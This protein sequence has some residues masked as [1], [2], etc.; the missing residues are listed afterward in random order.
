MHLST[1]KTGGA[2][3]RG[4]ASVGRRLGKWLAGGLA[5][6]L[7]GTAMVASGTGIIP[8]SAMEG[9][10]L[11]LV[12]SVDGEHAK[13]DLRPGDS[14]VYRVEFR[15]N[16][17]DADAPVLVRDAL[18][19][20]FA[21]W[22]ISNLTAVVGGSV[23]NVTLDLPGITSGDSPM[24]PA[25]GTIGSSEAERTITVG[26]AQPVQA[27][28]GN[29]SGLGMSTR[30]SGVLEYT[31]T[32]PGGLSPDDPI[33]R[34]DLVNTA[35]FTAKS[36]A[37]DLSTSDTAI[38]SVDNPIAVDVEP[39]KTWTPAAQNY[40]PGAASNMVIGARQ[41]SNVDASRLILQDPV[42]AQN[43]QTSL[44]ADNPFNYVD[45]AGFNAPAD[46]TGN[47]PTGADSVDVEV[48]R[49]NGTTWNWE[50]WNA[51]IPGSQ[52]G[53]IRT[54]YTGT[55]PPNATVSQGFAV[56]QRAT[57]RASGD[58]VSAGY[59]TLNRVRATVEVPGQDSVSKNAE[60]PFEVARERIGVVAQK[61]F[62][63]LPDGTPTTNLTEVTAGET[64]GVVLRAG[65]L[66]VPQST[67]LDRLIIAEPGDPAAPNNKF[68]DDDLVFGGFTSIS[69]P[70]GATGATVTWAHDGGPTGPVSF[71]SGTVPAPPAGEDV[72]GFT[73]E[74]TGAIAPNS[75]A[76]I[77]YELDSNASDAFVGPGE[78]KGPFLNIVDVTGERAGLDPVTESAE[79]SVSY[80]APKIE[81]TI[82]KRVGP[83]TVMPGQ[84]VIVQLDT[85]S[86]A[87]GGRTKPTKIE[88]TDEYTGAGTFWDAFDAKQI[89]PPISRPVNNGVPAT[90]T[91]EYLP[92][93]STVWQSLSVNPDENTPITVPNDA[94]GLR[95]A[96]ENTTEGLSKV[97]YVKPNI[98]FEARATLR[99]SGEPTGG[100]FTD[101]EM[102]RNTATVETEGWLDARKVEGDDADTADVGIRGTEGGTGPVPGEGPWAAKAWA[103]DVLTSQSGASS[104]TT[105]SWAVTEPGFETV[106]LQDPAS[107]T[108][109]AAKGEGTVF[110]AFNLTSI[111]PI[112]LSG[113]AGSGTVD[114]QLRWDLVTDVQLFNGTTGAWESVTPVPGGSW[115][116][117]GGFK[118]YTLTAAQQQSTVGVRLV[119][120]ENGPARQAAADAG[121]LTAPAVGSGVAA[122]AD[123]RQFRLDWQLRERAR[124]ADGSL[125]W[126]T[127]S[128]GFNCSGASLGCIDNV[129]GVTAV[130]G[131]TSQ[132]YT[133]SD[134][135]QLL[136][137]KANVA[138]TKDVRPLP[139]ADPAPAETVLVAPNEGEIAQADYPRARYTLT[140]TNSSQMP[141][142]AGGNPT[143]RGAMKLGKIR[144]TDT[145]TDAGL[146]PGFD[147]ATSPFTDRDFATEVNS[148]EG[149][150][151]D[152][153]TLT[154]VSFGT[155]PAYIDTAESTVELW[156]FGAP[157]GTPNQ[158][159]LAQ[160]QA[161]DPA[162]TA[163][164]QYAVG[165]AVTYSGTDPAQN[166][167]R[168]VVG[169]ALVAHLD[170][171]LRSH[172]RL[173]PTAPVTGGAAP[174]TV[175]VPNQAI[176]R[177]W[178][179]VVNPSDQPTDDDG[180]LVKL[181]EAQVRVSLEKSVSVSHG[182]TS[183]K[184]VYETDPQ[185]PISV[186]L[187]ARSSDAFGNST[188]PLNDLSISDRTDDFWDR[189]EFVSFG[190]PTHPSNADTAAFRVY[191]G[192]DWV[193]YDDFVAGGGDLA[194]IRGAGVVFTRSDGG[195]F[196]QGATSWN[197]S[198]GTA[199]LP[200]TVKLRADAVVD[201]SGDE[202]P[203][204]AA[205][206]ANNEQYG[207]AS[208]G[209]DDR[210]TFSPGV[211]QLR[212][213]KRA[214]N[215]TSTHQVEPLISLPW[216][217]QFTNTG[218]S[219]LP[220]TT[221]TDALP[222]TLSWDGEDPV[223]TSSVATSEL[224]AN[225]PDLFV[226]SSELV[227]DWSGSAPRMQPG[228]TV[229]IDLGLIMQPMTAGSRAT[230]EVVVRTGVPLAVCEQ[231]TD[232]GQDP[233]AWDPATPDE[234][235]NTNFVQPRV[236]TVIGARKTVSGEPGD[237]LG[238]NL[239]NGAL[240]VRNGEECKPG[241]FL[242]IG[243]DY[244]RNPCASYT[245]VG[246]TD[247]WKLENI[248][249][250]TQPFSRMTV[251][252]MLPNPG[253]KMLAGGAPRTSTFRPVLVDP[254]AIRL[255]GLPVGASYTV[256]VTT[257]PTACVGPTPGASLWVADPEC[258]DTAAN[259][260]N[261]WTMLA[262]Y[263]GDVEDIVGLR[264]KIDMTA[265]P[266]P[267]GGNV[268]VEF[269]TV[270]RVVDAAAE[271]L[272][273][274]LAQFETPQFAW[275]Q[276]GAIA[277]DV[278]GNR[279]NLPAAPQRAGVT[280][281]TGSLVVSKAILGEG[282]ANAPAS[283]P[284]DL[285]C[286]VPSGVADPERVPLD[287][288][289]SS[290]LTV[291]ANGSVTLTGL[292]IGTNC[293]LE[294]SGSVGAHGETGRSIAV[295]D[296]VTPSTDGL[297]AEVLIRERVGD[298]ATLV[299]L[300]NTYTLGELVVE[301]ALLSG[302]GHELSADQKKTVFEFELECVANGMNAPVQRSF[303]LKGGER[304]VE[305]G[306]PEGAT[307][308][309]EETSTGGAVRTTMTV[310]GVE[311]DG[312]S[313]GQLVITDAGLHVLVSNLLDGPTPKSLSVTGA[314][315]GLVGL[316][317][318]AILLLGFG[319]LALI[320]ARRRGEGDVG[321]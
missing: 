88:I 220:I 199:T 64:V 148:T 287:L 145:S 101:V 78:R 302:N 77:H 208:A 221:V 152:E 260:A 243:S 314:N 171:Q 197:A 117:S 59:Q 136:D 318:G 132:T 176:A 113:A 127:S 115:M 137:G 2:R 320:V 85:V 125:K 13:R 28:A 9:A 24:T 142:D 104:W 218:S 161:N 93:G 33:L 16:D 48:Y 219:Y 129:F 20:E 229:E 244:T 202:E 281:K 116:G 98:S 284:V 234:C 1:M 50:T 195:L 121:D 159:M 53:G 128:Q 225:A 254:N 47:L 58:S 70:A 149:N 124:T 265:N 310:A 256:E 296:G 174:G 35:T 139:V 253:D 82:E 99:S 213:V 236:G 309:L 315:S 300:S 295:T 321:D 83:G 182:A 167:N 263:T 226:S 34:H 237:T 61:G 169:D 308:T 209:A 108:G 81:P 42:T 26:V 264:V 6:L 261:V 297:S 299:N 228:E 91:I 135:I 10:S 63:T 72:T 19:A 60:A 279:L 95:F 86:E 191:D 313:L 224:T 179:A 46:P 27:G 130:S 138:F 71:A 268:I 3:K 41:A 49:F 155:L 231:P 143:A 90:L 223:I 5:A 30:D 258:A 193:S 283:F 165:I 230:N 303:Q 196:P 240:D 76:V 38:I 158:F 269:E 288:G 306:L 51:G 304:H 68:F 21:G 126:V 286:T 291:P 73:I 266:L 238:E 7:F 271:G 18:P 14:V 185:A 181:T 280:V 246:S 183:N 204:V 8:A 305:T 175:D 160:A 239:V 153:F 170:V 122:S 248:N 166:G 55:I 114:P 292:P 262:A 307:C 110:E 156:L 79:A 216:K 211:H 278:A 190:T 177:G 40:Q 232:F 272:Q 157:M 259:P 298:D 54:T 119:L 294:E 241:G 247:T 107:V 118:G 17:E 25:A 31:I 316:I 147:I 94:V 255:S 203:N 301:K 217:L 207:Q 317:T 163:A 162:F 66:D 22:Q 100:A 251:V 123:I 186:L 67:T 39:S 112:A 178:D 311:T 250:G 84:R 32:I 205:V 214:P 133:A 164:L 227:F 290:T 4:S 249:S 198:W 173:D 252:D 188:A 212:V 146:S 75:E 44:A 134:T 277:W 270:N 11:L 206:L 96:Y 150:H 37:A 154:G 103:H 274:N 233:E 97:T 144:V 222:A 56:E 215:D 57:H 43:G 74:F 275:N 293:V 80:V 172:H 15:V 312:A 140:A 89:L 29:A 92:A 180:A 273:P 102:Y 23:A 282:A 141:T 189:F 87:S 319:G 201:W 69:W 267:P 106:Y 289:A 200:F 62:Y 151:F 109:A 276:N 194:G 120:G 131:G 12:K 257:N 245:A 111:R 285:S 52:I 105:Q 187:T 65:N 45:F 242:P 235:S 210:V 192:S 36:G 168:I 184:T